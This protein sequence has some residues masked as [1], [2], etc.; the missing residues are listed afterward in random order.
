VIFQ[1]DDEKREREREMVFRFE[2]TPPKAMAFFFEK[3]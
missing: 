2:T 3:K 1:S